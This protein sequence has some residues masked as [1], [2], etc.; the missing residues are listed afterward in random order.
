[1]KI[2][3]KKAWFDKKVNKIRKIGETQEEIGRAHV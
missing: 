2:V 1:M 3:T